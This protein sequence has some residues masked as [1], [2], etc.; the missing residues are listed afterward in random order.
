MIVGQYVEDVYCDLED[1]PCGD[2]GSQED[3]DVFTGP[4]KRETDLARCKAGWERIGGRDVCPSCAEA[5]RRRDGGP[6]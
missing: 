6:P 5:I 2:A 1:H 4:D 3:P